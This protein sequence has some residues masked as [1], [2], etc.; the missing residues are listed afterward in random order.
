MLRRVRQ[1][2]S[3]D[4]IVPIG[5]TGLTNAKPM[6]LV[7]VLSLVFAAQSLVSGM[8][9]CTVRGG[10]PARRPGTLSGLST[11][12]VANPCA[13][14]AHAFCRPLLQPSISTNARQPTI[15]MYALDRGGD[16]ED[17]G[18]AE[19]L[20]GY[21]ADENFNDGCD[22]DDDNALGVRSLDQISHAAGV[23]GGVGLVLLAYAF[24]S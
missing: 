4:V 3:P 5:I 17:T 22:V 16:G 9:L 18:R 11:R 6:S 13:H 19:R 14:P 15:S 21:C 12:Q 10:A 8:L 7:A 1:R 2:H 24:L 20:A 23:A